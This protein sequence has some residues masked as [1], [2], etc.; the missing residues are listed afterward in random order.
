MDLDYIPYPGD[1]NYLG[2][3]FYSYAEQ[4]CKATCAEQ[5]AQVNGLDDG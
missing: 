4:C 1:D 5:C 3:V 2:C